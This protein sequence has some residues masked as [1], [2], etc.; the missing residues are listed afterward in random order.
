MNRTSMRNIHTHRYMKK[1][2]AIMAALTEQLR[3]NLYLSI[4][5]DE[6]ELKTDTRHA[7]RVAIINASQITAFTTLLNNAAQEDSWPEMMATID[8]WAE[9]TGV[10]V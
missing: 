8:D 4:K 9:A 3:T 7:K 1:I 10:K 6:D 2:D 5:E